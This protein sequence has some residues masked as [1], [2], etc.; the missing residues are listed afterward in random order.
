MNMSEPEEACPALY[1]IPL[2]AP[3]KRAARPTEDTKNKG[4][5]ELREKPSSWHWLEV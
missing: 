4:G 1:A 3:T 2:L 5:K